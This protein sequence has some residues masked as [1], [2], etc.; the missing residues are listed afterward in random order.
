MNT[1]FVSVA[2]ALALSVAAPATSAFAQDAGTLNVWGARITQ[3]QESRSFFGMPAW[4]DTLRNGN[5]NAD[6][7]TTGSVAPRRA[8]SSAK[9]SNAVQQ[10]R[11]V[12]QYGTTFDD[13]AE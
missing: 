9:H 6:T 7:Q 2:A 11:S 1:R 13:S 5:T 12:P 8:Y 3:P 4:V 10:Y